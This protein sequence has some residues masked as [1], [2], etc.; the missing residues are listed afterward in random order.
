MSFLYARPR[1]S[2]V[3]DGDLFPGPWPLPHYCHVCH[4]D[5][6]QMHARHLPPHTW[7]FAC[8]CRS[9][10]A[11][12][13][14]S[15]EPTSSRSRCTSPP[16]SRACSSC[17]S[18][19]CCAVRISPARPAKNVFGVFA[20]G[21]RQG[22]MP[23]SQQCNVLPS[24]VEGRL[25]VHAW[26]ACHSLTPHQALAH[27]RIMRRV[28]R[29]PSLPVGSIPEHAPLAPPPTPWNALLSWFRSCSRRCSSWP[30]ASSCRFCSATV[31]FRELILARASPST[32]SSA[33]TYDNQVPA[34]CGCMP[35]DAAAAGAGAYE[36]AAWHAVLAVHSPHAHATT[37][38]LPSPHQ[39]V[40]RPHGMRSLGRL[41]RP[42]HRQPGPAAHTCAVRS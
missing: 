35:R 32:F 18:A 7:R 20:V 21:H 1:L 14:L 22:L 31:P 5:A 39:P 40:Q 25:R 8:A 6:T 37:I 10:S 3:P 2:A 27:H 19:R 28:P 23:G 26:A 33:C 9:A 30:R 12:S 38:R 29:C 13:S 17:R 36:A 24:Y 16:S 11:A 4:P 41:H 34:W 15:L 42:H